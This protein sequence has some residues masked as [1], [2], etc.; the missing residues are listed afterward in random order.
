MQAK[1]RSDNPN[2]GTRSSDSASSEKPDNTVTPGTDQQQDTNG[3][4]RFRNYFRPKSGEPLVDDQYLMDNYFVSRGRRATYYAARRDPTSIIITETRNSI[5]AHDS[6]PDTAKSVI[7]VAMNKGWS[8]IK[9][10]G[11]KDFK[12]AA[13]LEAELTGIKTTGFKPDEQDLQQLQLLKART[14]DNINSI[15]QIETNLEEYLNQQGV[16]PEDRRQI[17]EL[18]KEKMEDYKTRGRFTT[19]PK[20]TPTDQAQ[21]SPQPEQQ[22]TES[23]QPTPFDLDPHQQQQIIDELVQESKTTKTQHDLSKPAPST[24]TPRQDESE[25]ER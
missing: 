15:E 3:N 20:Q 5:K 10:H 12:R 2:A 1:A 7:R 6:S 9:L 21:P 4:S 18:L 24:T 16:G 23:E 19:S 13:W 25:L 14:D 22:P 8:S 11:D 17:A